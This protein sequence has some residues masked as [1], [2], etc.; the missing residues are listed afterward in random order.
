METTNK[1]YTLNEAY[2]VLK[3][4]AEKFDWEIHGELPEEPKNFYSKNQRKR[5][6]RALK[7]ACEIGS[8]RAFNGLFHMISKI[9][10]EDQVRVTLGKKELE[11]QRKRKIWKKLQVD[12]DKALI[13]YKNEKGD[14][15]K[16]ILK[17]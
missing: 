14:F 6:A 2:R 15:Y 11:I 9:T 17:K 10:K 4:N 12:A 1:T 8:R 5:Y 13:E 3:Q 16:N 7:R